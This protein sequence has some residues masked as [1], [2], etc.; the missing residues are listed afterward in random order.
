MYSADGKIIG[1]YNA[2]RANRIPIPYSNLSPYLVQALVATEDVRFYDHSGIDF[3]ALG[4][5]IVKRGILGQVN[6]GGGSTITPQLAKQLYTEHPA[7]TTSQRLLQKPNEWVTAIKLERLYTKQE[8][9][10]LYLNYFDFLHGATGIK[11]ADNTYFNKEPKDL[12]INEAAL[13][14]GLCKNPSLF[15][16]VRY[17]D[18]A[19]ERR[20]VVLGQMLKAG[21][22]SQAQYDE[23]SVEPVKLNFHRSDHK[24]GTAVYFREFLRQYMMMDRPDPSNYPSWNKRQ[25]VID[26][27]AF[28]SDPLCGWCKKHTKRDGSFYNVYTD[29]LKIFTTIDSRMQRYAEESVYGHVARFLQPAFNK[30]NAGKANAPFS[31]NLTTKQVN[32]IIERSVTQSERYITM[33]ASGASWEEIHRAFH[34]PIDMTVFT[35][36]GEIDTV[37]SPIDS[38]RYYKRFLRAGFIL[39]AE[40]FRGG[41]E[42]TGFIAGLLQNV[43]NI[44]NVLR[45]LLMARNRVID[46]ACSLSHLPHLNFLL[47]YD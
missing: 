26:S 3:I 20:N 6:A 22:L 42:G 14:I 43:Q 45:H 12:D 17:P 11:T 23:L 10:A 25:Y 18:R 46:Q 1:T 9:I 15:N 39:R 2:D 21:Y 16:P 24:D 40:F 37:M 44:S 27:I 38:I 31:G 34:T 28:D 30:E 35:Y 41:S 4:R 33:K 7:K 32:Q 47:I 8:I 5:A 13:L 29:G 19:K 36:H